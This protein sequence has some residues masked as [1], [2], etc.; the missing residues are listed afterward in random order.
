MNRLRPE[1]ISHFAGLS[2]AEFQVAEFQAKLLETVTSKWAGHGN[3]RGLFGRPQGPN[4]T[5]A[6][7]T[8]RIFN[9]ANVLQGVRIPTAKIISIWKPK[10]EASALGLGG[11]SVRVLPVM[12]TPTDCRSQR[13][14]TIERM[15][16]ASKSR[17]FFFRLAAIALGLFPFALLE[18]GLR[19][20]DLPKRPPAVDP[21]VDLNALRPLFQASPDGERM[22]IGADRLHLFRPASFAN[23]KS[24]NAFRIFA[25]G[26]S[27]TQGEPYSTET[28][29]PAWMGITLQAACPELN[30][31]V[32]NCGGLSYASYRVLAVL[33]EVLQYEPD[34]IV[35]YTGHNEFLEDRTYAGYKQPGR[36]SKAISRLL[37]LRTVQYAGAL[38]GQSATRR[39]SM[40]E[41]PTKMSREVDALLDYRGGLENYHRDP[42][43]TLAVENHFRWN[44]EQMIHACQAGGI[45]L[46]LVGPVSNELDCP[47]FK[48]EV[49]GEMSASAAAHF[50]RQWQRALTA[51]SLDSGLASARSA[52]AKD[53]QHAGANFF[54]GQCLAQMGE[55]E[56]AQTYLRA[57]KDMDVC[58]LRATSTIHQTVL[59][60]AARWDVPVVDA[61]ALFES[62]SDHGI[63]GDQW[64]VDHI[65][66]SVAGHQW[67]GRRIADVC[68]AQ[69]GWLAAQSTSWE[70]GLSDRFAQHL[71]TLGEAYF[72]HGK[73]RLEGLRLWT[74]GRA[75]KTSSRPNGVPVRAEQ[76][77]KEAAK[78]NSR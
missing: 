32:V 27:T 51:D 65:H 20:F 2:F 73:Q 49:S 28:A 19:T 14:D 39:R 9:S 59:D 43:W 18:I 11:R 69:R 45:P 21:F 52:L 33:R 17:R 54:I 53:P 47:P 62:H 26:G 25:L 7:Q 70:E 37:A 74:Q 64:L 30:M 8:T 35:I 5:T 61:Q 77:K 41:R 10:L 24:R 48:I 1:F 16:T 76:S 3:Q 63:V 15:R 60:L 13:L 78:L 67:L 38:F 44:L 57:A 23:A 75:Q 58:P 40:G 50:D 46:V 66:P 36:W 22:Q 31:E 55:Y 6:C 71:D 29:F 72:H 34:L 12:Q 68:L 42:T 4:S 56:S